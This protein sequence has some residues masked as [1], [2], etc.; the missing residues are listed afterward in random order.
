MED[1]AVFLQLVLLFYR[2]ENLAKKTFT[3]SIY[4]FRDRNRAQGS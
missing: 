3:T 4:Y 2:R 1:L